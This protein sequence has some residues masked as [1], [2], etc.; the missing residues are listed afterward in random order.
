MSK[1]DVGVGEA[2]PLDHAQRKERSVR[3]GRHTHNHD[4]TDHHHPDKAAVAMLFALK[5]YRRRMRAS[6]QPQQG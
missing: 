1:F 5:A 6:A 2:F 3:C 4:C